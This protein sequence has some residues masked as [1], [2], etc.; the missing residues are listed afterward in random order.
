MT[1]ELES[2]KVLGGAKRIFALVLVEKVKELLKGS[3]SQIEFG[4]ILFLNYKF[5]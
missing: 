1:R 4:G 3:F 2:K 5:T